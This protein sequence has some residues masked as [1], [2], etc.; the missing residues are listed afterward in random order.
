MSWMDW[1]KSAAAPYV[2]DMSPAP[3]QRLVS[4]PRQSGTTALVAPAPVDLASLLCSALRPLI[5]QAGGQGVRLLVAPAPDFPESVPADGLKLAWAVSALV[6]S[7]LRFTRRGSVMMPGGSIVV[8]IGWEAASR[9]AVI[10]V[11]DDGR[12]IPPEVFAH[13]LDRTVTAGRMPSLQLLMIEDL[14]HAHGGSLE[15]SSVHD[16]LDGGTTVTMRIPC[17]PRSD[18][19]SL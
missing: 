4:E 11:T 2:P 12:G 8:R 7:A 9:T 17:A 15:I 18:R 6:G 10:Q 16:G 14:V 1:F 13:M 3:V 5:V 19:L